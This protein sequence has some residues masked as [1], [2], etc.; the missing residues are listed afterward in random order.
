MA[1][2]S[3]S[4]RA[5]R[6]QR[7][8]RAGSNGTARPVAR[9]HRGRLPRG[10]D[11]VLPDVLRRPLADRA[12]RRR[13]TSWPPWSSASRTI[14]IRLDIEVL[15]TQ[16]RRE[17]SAAMGLGDEA[18]LAIFVRDAGRV[19]AG[20]SG[21]T[22]GDCC[23]LQSLWV[24]PSLRGRGLATRLIAAAEAEAAARGC[25]Q[26][27]HF[28]YAFQAR[29]LYERNGYELVG[30]VEDFPSG[31]D[32]LWYRKRLNPPKSP[33]SRER[34]RSEKPGENTAALMTDPDPGSGDAVIQPDGTP[35][36]GSPESSRRPHD[37]ARQGRR[38]AGRPGSTGSRARRIA[39]LD[40][41]QVS[42]AMAWV[43]CHPDSG[44][45]LSVD[46][47]RPAAS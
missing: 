41:M 4:H 34:S 28:T 37:R 12:D 36:P 29:A 47:V 24:E 39:R 33:P 21:W 26:T 44:L 13:L 42:E 30:R 11:P 25:S 45:K 46:A 7:G 1:R 2:R 38:Q 16:I 19:V 31:T 43:S 15:E 40:A 10:E 32:V 27:V 23:E 22:W 18:D 6:A 35:R 5:T 8:Y 3:R 20:I 9:R 14:R 17:A